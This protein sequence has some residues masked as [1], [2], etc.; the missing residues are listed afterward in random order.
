M[1]R[2]FI[3]ADG[4]SVAITQMKDGTFAVEIC[5]KDPAEWVPGGSSGVRSL[6][7]ALKDC[8]SLGLMLN[9]AWLEWRGLLND[10]RMPEE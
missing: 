7:V 10:E 1:P 2:R 4:M 5:A 3:D 9:K 8:G 6:R